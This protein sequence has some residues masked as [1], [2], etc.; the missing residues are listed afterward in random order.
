[1]I[2][3]IDMELFLGNGY[4]LV[5]W[6]KPDGSTWAVIAPPQDVVATTKHF[7]VLG[8]SEARAWAEKV[9]VD[10]GL[11]DRVAKWVKTAEL[12]CDLCDAQDCDLYTWHVAGNDLD[13]CLS[14]YRKVARAAIGSTA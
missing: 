3:E 4:R 9:I 10:L 1:M 8:E 2:A 7:T 6:Y 11:A 14:C 12:L 5:H 13:L